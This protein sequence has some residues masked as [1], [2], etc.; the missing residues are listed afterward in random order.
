MLFERQ[1][2]I[3]GIFDKVAL[4]LGEF[5]KSEDYKTYIF[6]TIAKAK[7]KLNNATK[8]QI[9]KNDEWLLPEISALGFEVEFLENSRIGGCIIVDMANGIRIDETFSTK[10]ESAENKF[11]ETYN[12]KI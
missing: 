4:R 12:L 1:K 8:V 10:L 5:T 6:D 11:L 2:Q 3:D 7:Q 9:V